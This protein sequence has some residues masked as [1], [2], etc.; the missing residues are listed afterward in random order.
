MFSC[1]M[2]LVA[3]DLYDIAVGP[4][5]LVSNGPWD[6]FIICGGPKQHF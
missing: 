5:S 1:S 2:V 4:G 3:L 6:V